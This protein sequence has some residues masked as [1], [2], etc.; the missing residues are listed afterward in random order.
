MPTLSET[1]RFGQG[2]SRNSYS[3]TLPACKSEEFPLFVKEGSG[4]IFTTT[5]LLKIERR[6]DS[7]K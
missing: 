1:D 5:G 2:C 4:E 7:L 6:K 3:G